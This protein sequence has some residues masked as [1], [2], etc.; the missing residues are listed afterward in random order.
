MYVILINHHLELALNIFN[1]V[2][3]YINFLLVVIIYLYVIF[4][5][6]IVE[7]RNKIEINEYIIARF[8]YFQRRFYDIKQLY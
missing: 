4:Y 3:L 5:S 1:F 2:N 7:N 6:T 8:L